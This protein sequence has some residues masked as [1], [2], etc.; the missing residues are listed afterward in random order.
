MEVPPGWR[1][2][3]GGDTNGEEVP[4]WR[5]YYRAPLSLLHGGCLERDDCWTWLSSGDV[6]VSSLLAQAAMSVKQPF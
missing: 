3:R 4:P 6:R 1:Y 5:R 2:H